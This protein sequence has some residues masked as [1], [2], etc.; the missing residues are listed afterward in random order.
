MATQSLRE[1]VREDGLRIITKRMLSTKKVRLA[2]AGLVGDAY[3][4]LYRLKGLFHFFEHTAF[5]GTETRTAEEMDA[6]E[7]THLDMINAYTAPLLTNY[8]GEALYSRFDELCDFIFDTYLRSTYPGD[9]L[10]KEKG[11]IKGEIRGSLDDDSHQVHYALNRLLWQ[12]NPLRNMGVRGTIADIEKVSRELLFQIKA[13]W[14]I[15]SNTVVIGTG[16][17]DHDELVR[18]AY[19]EFP[20]NDA[21]VSHPVWD[22]EFP[23]PPTTMRTVITKPGRENALIA[24][25]CKIGL[26][27]DHDRGVIEILH[28]M[29]TGGQSTV[30]NRELR[31]R[32][33]WTYSTWGNSYGYKRLGHYLSFGTEMDPEQLPNA[34]NL[35]RE[36]LFDVPLTVELFTR[37]RG[38]LIQSL[39]LDLECPDTWESAILRCVVNN[40]NPLAYLN[41]YAGRYEEDLMRVTFDEVCAMR[42]KLLRP[43]TTAF[44][45]LKPE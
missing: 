23:D 34:E 40:D 45:I 8:Y 10:E 27:P 25:G 6:F 26:F 32:R 5:D 1:T 13:Q 36:L 38:R 43:E 29:F 33:G 35:L 12:K 9:E 3:D 24:V 11:A 16:M 21:I 14:L 44:A 28:E 4:E 7:D 17:I 18:A 20:L 39:I 22:L 37:I 42:N 30:L 19:R 41:E 15:P 2:V 31:R